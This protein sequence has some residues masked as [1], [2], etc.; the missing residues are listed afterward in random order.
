VS[1]SI[2]TTGLDDLIQRLDAAGRAIEGVG[3]RLHADAE[4]AG[5]VENG[6]RFMAAHPYLAPA[7]EET[8][9]QVAALA[10]EG[11][12]AMIET[13]DASAL[14]R[15]LETGARL[16]ETRAQAI[17]NVVRGTLRTS[18]HAEVT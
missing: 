10:A 2:E 9:D 1:V 6:T 18:I 7:E 12:T 11:V 14:R 13:G 4:Y 16:M 3:I 17:V 15:N 8:A 5:F